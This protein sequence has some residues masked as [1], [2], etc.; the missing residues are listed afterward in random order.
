[1]KK[2]IV[3][4]AGGN[5]LLGDKLS[6]KYIAKK[7][8]VVII[9]RNLFSV[10]SDKIYLKHD[11]SKSLN[12]DHINDIV[13]NFTSRLKIIIHVIGG[14]IKTTNILE[15]NSYYYEKFVLSY[16]NLILDLKNIIKINNGY[17][18]YLSSQM[19]ENMNFNNFS[20]CSS[21]LQGENITKIIAREFHSSQAQ[22]LNIRLKQFTYKDDK[23][24]TDS[25]IDKIS[26][27]ITKLTESTYNN[28]C[29]VII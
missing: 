26:A 4:I 27:E 29:T 8:Q 20:Y 11:L 13:P 6:E 18:L 5:S 7:Y 25:T 24:K 12:L 10:S 3:L 1:M 14:Y 17:I 19:L 2:D 28:G 15:A 23:A 9:S 21:K 16:F 22:A